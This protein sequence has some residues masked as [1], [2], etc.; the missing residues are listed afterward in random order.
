MLIQHRAD[1]IRL[2]TQ[3]DH[4]LVAGEM[5]RRWRGVKTDTE[6]PSI[7]AVLAIALHDSAWIRLDAAAPFDEER[8][9]PWDFESL[10]NDEK[11][12]LYATGIDNLEPVQP[13]ASLLVSLHYDAFIP[14]DQYPDF[15]RSELQRQD[16]LR[17][18]LRG[19]L[20]EGVI[21]RDIALLRLLDLL[22]LRVCLT[23]PG[24]LDE[25]W[26]RWILSPARWD[27]TE[28]RTAWTD[29]RTLS[30]DPFPFAQPLAL[31]V[32]VTT[33]FGPVGTTEAQWKRQLRDASRDAWSVRVEPSSR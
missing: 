29:E 9:V 22:A 5:A 25:H 12:Q 20:N 17:R 27:D 4:A 23:P 21:E 32:P 30:F 6:P 11:A 14:E 3:S 7:E 1:S 18:V 13:Y 26:P 28:I 2:I 31:S 10:P 8:G 16:R 33:V 24:S 15:H 19:R